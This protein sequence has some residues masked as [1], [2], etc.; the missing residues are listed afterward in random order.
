MLKNFESL[1][2]T[3]A[4]LKLLLLIIIIIIGKIM[5]LIWDRAKELATTAGKKI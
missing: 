4:F 2:L 5:E 3:F 1:N